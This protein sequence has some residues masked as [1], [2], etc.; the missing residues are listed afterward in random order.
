MNQSYSNIFSCIDIAQFAGVINVWILLSV[1]LHVPGIFSYSMQSGIFYV[2]YQCSWSIFCQLHS[3]P[4][5]SIE[6]AFPDWYTLRRLV[7]QL[8]IEGCEFDERLV[9]SVS[10][11]LIRAWLCLE[12]LCQDRFQIER[13]L[14][15]SSWITGTNLTTINLRPCWRIV[16]FNID[17][18]RHF[19]QAGM[20]VKRRNKK[21]QASSR[22][23][24]QSSPLADRL[25]HIIK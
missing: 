23:I 20:F 7:K 16:R 25:A 9:T 4:L 1:S 13:G 18:L 10:M 8:L 17:I 21:I 12:F 15:W 14:P 3:M 6:F 24:H 11:D 2:H 5:K 22:T 19:L